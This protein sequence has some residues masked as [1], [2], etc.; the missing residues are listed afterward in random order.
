MPII[1]VSD[2]LILGERRR[3]QME[4]TIAALLLVTSSVIFACI[5]IGYGIE[6]TQQSISDDSAQMKLLNELQD[7]L[8]NQTSSIDT[9]LPT[10]PEP[11]I[12]P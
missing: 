12:S 11:T 9:P 10:N 4:S 2:I 3:L 1:L 8:I 7:T 5:V 6:M